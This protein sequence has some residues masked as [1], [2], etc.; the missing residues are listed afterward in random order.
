MCSFR[1]VIN[2]FLCILKYK[3]HYLCKIIIYCLTEKNILIL[4]YGK[5]NNRK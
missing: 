2:I 3:K 1:D 4:I 5:E